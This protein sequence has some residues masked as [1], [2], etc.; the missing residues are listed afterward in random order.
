MKTLLI[1][2]SQSKIRVAFHQPPALPLGLAYIAAMLEQSHGVKILD[3]YLENL[4]KEKLKKRIHLVNPEIVGI[5]S[6]SFSFSSAVEI[7]N[8]V[9]EVDKNIITVIGGPHANVF[10]D[11]PLKY[12]SIDISVYGEGELTAIELWDKIEK[13]ESL[14]DVK[15]IGY[16]NNG[17]I[18]INPPRELIKNLDELPFPARHLFPMDRYERKEKQYLGNI[19][20]IDWLTTSRGCVFNCTFCDNRE[21]FGNYR[22]RSPENV[23]AEIELLVSEYGIKGVYFRES[24]FTL[25]KKRV[26]GICNELK[27]RGLDIVWA[28]DSRIDTIDKE[29]LVSMKDAGCRTVWFGIESGTQEILDYIHKEVTIPQIKDVVKLS[30]ECGMKVG[31]S[32]M[33]GIP[34][35]TMDQMHETINFACELRPY[36]EFAWFAAYLGIPKSQLYLYSKENNFIDEDFGNG[37]FT[38]KTN[39]FDRASMEKLMQYATKKFERTPSRMFRKVVEAIKGGEFTVSKMIKGFKFYFGA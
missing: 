22:F 10:P 24:L 16:K 1:N 36:L 35:E 39:E 13:G 8:I 4:N 27:E 14:K 30:K 19:V 20:P 17:K 38:V 33:I 37:V 11:A 2:P 9:T 29:M 34:G 28:C 32:F 15:G 7:A 26:L 18:I 3:N 21:I 6:D 12:D 5:T 31:G 23:V 25:N